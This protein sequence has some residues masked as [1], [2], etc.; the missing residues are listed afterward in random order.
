MSLFADV[1]KNVLDAHIHAVME[2]IKRLPDDEKIL[3]INEIK[4][5]LQ[6]ISPFKNEPVDCVVWV[7]EAQ[8]QANDYNPNTVAPPEMRLLELSISEDGFTQPIVVVHEK[9]EDRNYTVID[10]FHRNRVGKESKKVKKR[11]MNYLPIAI[12]GDENTPKEKRIASTIRHNRARGVHGVMPMIDIVAILIKNGL[13]D[14][15]VAKNLGMDP[16]EVLRFKQATGLPELY[17]DHEYSQSWE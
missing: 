2:I 1:E 4:K 10:G 8:V 11:T 5:N 12:A 17:K 3:A 16:D 14:E 7:P 9:M 15:E 13:S 6:K